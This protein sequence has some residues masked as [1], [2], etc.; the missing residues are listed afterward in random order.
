MGWGIDFTA[1]IYLSRQNYY[2][3]VNLVQ[4]EIDN[5]NKQNQGLKERMLMMVAGGA[6]SVSV[7]DVEGNECDP[8]DVLHSRFNELLQTYDENNAKIQDL[9]YYKVY[10]EEKHRKEGKQ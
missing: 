10:L 1:D 3:N 2:E 9:Y 7:K 6:S 5:L 8:V 4:D